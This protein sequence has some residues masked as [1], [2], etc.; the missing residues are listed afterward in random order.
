[1]ANK[2]GGSKSKSKSGAGKTKATMK[3]LEPRGTSKVRGGEK[4]KTT[5][6]SNLQIMKVLDKTTP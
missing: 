5:T 3:D 2:S 6:Y 1:M 4:A